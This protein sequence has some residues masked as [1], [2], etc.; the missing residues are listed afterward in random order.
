MKIEGE[1]RLLRI[2]INETDEWEGHPLYKVIVE[3]LRKAHFAGCTVLCG[4]QGFG[5]GRQM[6]DARF[7]ILFMD[8]PI[9]I[10]VVET[11]AKI[12]QM[13]P[14]LDKMIKVGMM[15]L[16]VVD[17]EMYRADSPTPQQ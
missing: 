3:K 8:L 17:V 14:E 12:N 15:T 11:E 2:F 7:E 9:I 6:H 1:Q 16:E 4:M 13:I 10:E 5:S